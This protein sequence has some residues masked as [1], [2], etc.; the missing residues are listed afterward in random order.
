[1]AVRASVGAGAT[2]VEPGGSAAFDVTLHNDGPD[3]ETVELRIIGE[4]RPFAY[5]VPS[6]V[7]LPAAGESTVRLGFRLPRA[8]APEAGPLAYAIQATGSGGRTGILAGGAI[9]VAPFSA[10]SVTLDPAEVAGAG[11][12]SHVLT[13]AN[14]GNGPVKVALAA[15]RSDR[16][17]ITIDPPAV[18]A[19]P[20]ASGRTAV[21]VRPQARRFTGAALD[22]AFTIEARPE[23]GDPV[24]VSG[25]RRVPPTVPARRLVGSGAVVGAVALALA[26]VLLAAAGRGSTPRAGPDGS[27]PA[28]LPACPARGHLD[29]S[30]ANGLRPEEIP[31]LPNTY[32]FLYVKNDGCTPIRFNPCEPVHYVQNAALAPPTGVA[33]VRESF[34]RLARATGMEFVDDG[35]TDEDGLG[36]RRPYQ[37]DRYGARWAPVLVTWSR[38]GFQGPNPEVQSVGYGIGARV[39]DVL[40]TGVLNL[41]V[42]A[43]T[44]RDKG[45]PVRGGFGPEIGTGSGAIGAEGVTWGRIIQ[46]ELAHVI[47]L[48]HT[49]DRGAIMYP[50]SADQTS[51][52]AE[53]R[54]PDREGL[55]YLGREAGCLATPPLPA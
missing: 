42:D 10:L 30:G 49:R 12:S 32:S 53:F 28:P 13:V 19:A 36:R 47:G 52:P 37:P 26:V 9:E 48:G 8:S 18:V 17:H 35:F 55:R 38:F 14:R 6:C 20:G 21:E 22:L 34:A 39:G 33:D 45:T 7:T 27:G 1:M 4:G 43:V 50:E 46:H 3:A 5:V 24:R 31:N 23:H 40:V 11:P 2:R 44:D 25:R 51:R 16:L 41:N 29:V 54:P 15:T